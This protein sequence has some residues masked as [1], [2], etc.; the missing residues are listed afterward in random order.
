M[1]AGACSRCTTHAATRSR[2]E[3]P[4]RGCGLPATRAVAAER[5]RS[6][7]GRSAWDGVL[8]AELW[9]PTPRFAAAREEVEVFP[10]V[11]ARRPLIGIS[12]YPRTHSRTGNREVFPLPTSYVDAVRAAGGIPVILPPGDADPAA[13][14]DDIDGLVLS[15]GGDVA[16]QRYSGGHHE[17]IYGVS[18]E[19]D[20]FEIAL[21]KAALDREDRPFFCICRGL[22]V[23][24]V[25]LGGDL[26][27]HLPDLGAS[28]VEHRLPERLHTHHKASVAPD[29][30]LAE[31]LESTEVT[32]CSW[33]H[34]AIRRLAP[35]LHPVAWAED[36][37]I[38]AVEHDEHPLC[39]AVQWHPEMQLEDPA[40]QRLFRAFVALCAARNR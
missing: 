15:G 25:A 30:R 26:H 33:H 6:R 11:S 17:T 27:S 36:G 39:V 9:P 3:C 4:T 23:L 14:L 2:S 16:P 29:S 1:R 5:P 7:R 35:G 34:Q 13:V 18:E 12:S 31:M 37:I 40:Q 32:V 24:N 19:R 28:T 20:G 21:A 10:H 22:Q 8:R 38:E